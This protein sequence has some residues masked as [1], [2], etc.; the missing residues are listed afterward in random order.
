M[1]FARNDPT[2]GV[3][4]ALMARHLLDRGADPRAVSPFPTG[5]AAIDELLSGA[6]ANP[7]A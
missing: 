6:R 5:I 7:L 3:D 2:P 1:Y 4:Y